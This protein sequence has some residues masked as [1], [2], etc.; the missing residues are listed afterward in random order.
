MLIFFSVESIPET[1]ED[2]ETLRKKALKKMKKKYNLVGEEYRVQ[3]VTVDGR[4]ADRAEE[5]RQTIGSDN[6]YQREDAPASVDR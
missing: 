3:D 4:Y 2:K 1:K 5:R 6:P